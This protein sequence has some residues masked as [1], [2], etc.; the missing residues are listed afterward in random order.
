MHS[1]LGGRLEVPARRARWSLSSSTSLAQC[2]TASL[3]IR[4]ELQANTDQ[5]E[6]DE[7]AKGQGLL[8]HGNESRQGRE[9]EYQRMERALVLNARV[10]PSPVREARSVAAL[11]RLSKEIATRLLSGTRMP[12]TARR[13]SACRRQ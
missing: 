6:H 7:I 4:R 1:A 10:S 2:T 5:S 12:P 8:V 3:P 11:E 13:S 9:A